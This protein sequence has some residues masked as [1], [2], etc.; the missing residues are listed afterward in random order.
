MRI[1]PLRR[2]RLRMG[3]RRSSPIPLYHQIRAL[4]LRQ[5]ETG[6]LKPGDALPSERELIDHY[7]VSRI[8]VRQALNSLAVDGLLFRQPGRGTF[9]RRSRIEQ[10]LASL[11]GFSEEMLSRGLTPSTRLI[12]TAMM[13]PT[14]Q[15]AAW[16]R[17][18]PGQKVLQMVRLRLADGEPMAVDVNCIPPDLG[19]KLL[20]DNLEEAL[21]TLFEEK[22]GVELDWSDEAIEARL[23]DESTARLL[24]IRKGMPILFMERVTY[25]VD[26]RPV[27]V[28]QTS[29][30]ADRYSYR[31]RLKRKPRTASYSGSPPG[32]GAG[33]P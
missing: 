33:A 15:V 25:S 10:E 19:E 4:L 26:G 17:M 12:S 28:A 30:R 11:T 7:G 32:V 5:I 31:V 24:A 27:E 13:E 22:Y 9:V 1:C 29:Y 6:Q 3:L 21:Y 18:A 8:T 2:V 16:L 23:P 20:K 14:A